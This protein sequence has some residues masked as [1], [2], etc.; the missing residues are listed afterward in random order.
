VRKNGEREEGKTGLANGD[1]DCSGEFNARADE[2]SHCQGG[3][4]DENEHGD[5]TENESARNGGR[6]DRSAEREEHDGRGEACVV[7]MNCGEKNDRLL[8]AQ[9]CEAET[10]SNEPYTADGD[11]EKRKRARSRGDAAVS[12]ADEFE[13]AV[14]REEKA[15]Y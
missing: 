1:G 3:G 9:G 6:W 14:Q 4:A 11:V 10:R 7:K 5:D 8:E 2:K 13:E 15:N 12:A